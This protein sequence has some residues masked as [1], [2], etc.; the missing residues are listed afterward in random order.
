LVTPPPPPT[1]A[2]SRSMASK[3]I[4]PSSACI[5]SIPS[6]ILAYRLPDRS[7]VLVNRLKLGRG[8][9]HIRI[10]R[11]SILADL[12]PVTVYSWPLE[13]AVGRTM[14]I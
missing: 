1:R 12:D 10:K 3:L 9:R 8:E 11:L 13:M 7:Q 4:I 6:H 5:I 2:A 14:V